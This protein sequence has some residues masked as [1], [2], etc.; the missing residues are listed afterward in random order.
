MKKLFGQKWVIQNMTQTYEFDDKIQKLNWVELI[1]FI[2]TATPNYDD[3][4]SDYLKLCLTSEFDYFTGKNGIALFFTT[5][6]CE[7]RVNNM[8]LDHR[9]FVKKHPFTLF[10]FDMLPFKSI[11]TIAAPSFEWSNKCVSR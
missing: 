9:A 3:L 1:F 6:I 11:Y 2:T 10:Y 8:P 7:D 5:T 4:H